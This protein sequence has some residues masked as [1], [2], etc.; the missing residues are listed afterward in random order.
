MTVFAFLHTYIHDSVW[1]ALV[2]IESCPS[3]WSVL[4]L[5]H[6]AV[7][8][9]EESVKTR[10]KS[11]STGMTGS[12]ESKRRS[13][14]T[15]QPDTRRSQ[16]DRLLYTP[17]A[18]R[19]AGAVA[20]GIF[21]ER[22][23]TSA[24]REGAAIPSDPPPLATT[25]AARPTAPPPRT[26]PRPGLQARPQASQSRPPPAAPCSSPRRGRWSCSRRTRQ[27]SRAASPPAI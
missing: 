15:L 10:E 25:V 1:S 8:H 21:P 20:E 14:R 9:V 13:H 12:E 26:P 6:T 18:V 5:A 4:S 24:G 19:V 3:P 23:N 22:T 2:S 17:Y 27:A 7:T 11:E 16:N